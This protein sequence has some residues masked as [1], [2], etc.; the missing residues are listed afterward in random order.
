MSSLARNPNGSSSGLSLAL[1]LQREDSG[2][3][4]ELFELYGPLVDRWATAAGL[5]KAARQDIAQEV[6]LLVHRSISQFDATGP[7]ATFKGWLWR[8]TRNVV[9]QHL[10]KTN[11]QPR[12]G[13][14]AAAR[15]A[16]FADPWEGCSDDDPPSS[17]DETT[18]LVRRAMHQIESRVD[19]V[20]WQAFFRTTINGE[21]STDVA[22]DLGLSPAAVRKAKSRTLQRLRKQLGDQA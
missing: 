12:G 21:R 2:A 7:K 3:W 19:P 4:S 22:A 13:S 17:I 16:E 5:K 15:L 18:A 6:F 11:T 1:R 9:L 14:T 10:R 8:I 20:T